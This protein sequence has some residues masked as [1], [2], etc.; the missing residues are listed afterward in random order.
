VDLYNGKMQRLLDIHAP[1]TT[2]NGSGATIAGAE[3]RWLSAA[4]RDAKRRCRWA[5]DGEGRLYFVTP[6]RPM[7][8][9]GAPLLFVTRVRTE[10]A[11]RA[12][13]VAGPTVFNSLPPKI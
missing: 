9:A 7:R 8:S 4:A 12:F 3:H 6:A 5:M 10:L 11:R 1:L 2:R 13:S